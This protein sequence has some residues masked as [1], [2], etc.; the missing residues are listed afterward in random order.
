MAS[1]PNLAVFAAGG[2]PATT[3]TPGVADALQGAVD[4]SGHPHSTV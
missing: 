4:G 2:E 3:V 1:S